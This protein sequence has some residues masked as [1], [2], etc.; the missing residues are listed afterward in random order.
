MLT[1]RFIIITNDPFRT[2]K[3]SSFQASV[4]PI[5]SAPAENGNEYKISWHSID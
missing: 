1:L 5:Q 4:G 3:R 2:Q